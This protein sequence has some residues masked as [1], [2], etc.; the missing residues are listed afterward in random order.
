MKINVGDYV[1]LYRCQGIR[2]IDE[3]DEEYDVYKL[4]MMIYNLII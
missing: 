3:Y 4:D 2:R 1:R